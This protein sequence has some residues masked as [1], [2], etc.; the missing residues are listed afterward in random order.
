M[1]VNIRPALVRTG[2]TLSLVTIATVLVFP[3]CLYARYESDLRDGTLAT[4]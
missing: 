4:L 2:G 3:L 1:I